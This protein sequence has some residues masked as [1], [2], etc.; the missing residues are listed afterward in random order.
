MLVLTWRKTREKT[1]ILRQN[2]RLVTRREQEQDQSHQ[3][4]KLGRFRRKPLRKVRW[5]SSRT[6]ERNYWRKRS[7]PGTS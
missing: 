7:Q 4:K 6:W 2:L 3:T 1:Q 5:G